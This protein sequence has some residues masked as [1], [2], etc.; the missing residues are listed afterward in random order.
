LSKTQLENINMLGNI[1]EKV[2]S[3][4]DRL[5]ALTSYEGPL[6]TTNKELAAVAAKVDTVWASDRRAHK[7]VDKVETAFKKDHDNL[8]SLI[9]R[10]SMSTA[11]VFAVLT[12]VLT[13]FFK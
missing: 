11:G 4:D 6:A 10:V 1:N 2:N 5:D 12:F 7:R 8:T 9:V 3:I 13:I